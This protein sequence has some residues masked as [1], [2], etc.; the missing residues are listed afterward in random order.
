ME[1]SMIEK[2]E[3]QFLRLFLIHSSQKE[4]V[5]SFEYILGA[6]RTLS[7]LIRFI[8]SGEI[9]N[10]MA[11]V[12]L[13]AAKASLRKVRFAS[14]PKYQVW[15]A[16]GQLETAYQAIDSKLRSVQ[17]WRTG[18]MAQLMMDSK[19]YDQACLITALMSILYKYL[20]EEDLCLQHLDLASNI[21]ESSFRFFRESERE[22]GMSPWGEFY[23]GTGLGVIDMLGTMGFMAVNQTIKKHILKQSLDLPITAEDIKKLHRNLFNY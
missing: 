3:Y 11:E 7:G 23:Y 18:S 6:T 14:N 1:V 2:I 8:E 13:S 9:L 17:G 22:S 19:S 12:E 15:N 5:M 4:V 21:A 10:T 20:E 16:V